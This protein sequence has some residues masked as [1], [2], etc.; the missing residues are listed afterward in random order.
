MRERTKLAGLSGEGRS[1]ATTLLVSTALEWMNSPGSGVSKDKR[2]LLG[3]TD[4]R[5]DAALQAGHFNDFL[6]VSLLRGAILRAV[7]DAGDDGMTEDQFGL[8][9][10]KALGFTVGNKNALVHWMANPEGRTQ[11]RED[12]QRALA[13]VLAHRVWTDLRRGWRYTNPSLSVL[14]LIDVTFS[15]LDDI[16]EDKEGFASILPAL[17]T[18][19][20]PA[21]MALLKT[22]LSAMLEGLAVSAEAL[23]PVEIDVIAQNSRNHL[24]PPW[25]MDAKEKPRSR[26]TL[27]LQ[28]PG[29]DRVGLKE[30]QTIIR[31]GHNSRIGRLINRETMIGTKLGRADYLAML[32]GLMEFLA[33]EGLVSRVDLEADQQGWRLSPSAVRIVPGEALRTVSAQ[34][35]RYFHELYHAIAADLKAGRSHYWGIEGREHTAQVSQRQ[36]EW[37]EWR[38]R[39][40]SEDKENLAKN[41]AELKAAGESEQFLPALFCSPTMELGVDIS[42]LNAVYL[43]NV[44]PT[45]ANYAQR[46]GRAGRSGQAALIMTYCAAQSPHD[47]YFF[48]RRNDM[49]A[50]DVR[51]PALDIS[52]E[53]L[54]RSHL[55]AVWLAETKLALSP[56]IPQI[57]DLT[58]PGYPLKPEISEVIERPKLASVARAPMKRVLDQILDSLHG[59][60]PV[61]MSEPDRFV[62]EV[63]EGAPLEFNRAFKRWRD[64]YASARTQL[65]E[66][67]ERSL[68]TG[69]SASDRRQVK[70]AQMQASDQIALL[71]Q[72]KASNG[73]DFYS[74]RYLATEGFL[75]GYN[76]PRLPLYAF[77]PGEGKTGSFLQR[78][79]FLAISEF[80]PRSLI[81]HEGRAYRVIKAKLPPEVRKGDGAELATK[82]IFICANC[83]ACHDDEVERCHACNSP[84]AGEAQVKGTLRI[85]NVEAALAER[86]TANDEERVRQGFEIQTVFSWP[87]QDGRAD[88]VEAVF[89]CGEKAIL[90]L[91]YAN[92]ADISRINKGLKR[93]AN[94][95][96]FGFYIDPRSGYWAK[97]AD[98]DDADD[99]PPDVVNPVRI[100]PI[101]RDRK[102]ALLSVSEIPRL[103]RLRQSQLSSM[104]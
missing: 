64:L 58:Q 8:R 22:L 19:D 88:I 17:G 2:K 40:E 38:F 76:F 24:R 9:T 77:I 74:Y 70:A 15:G 95:T 28:A 7:L 47:Q 69:L 63:A 44:P 96:E 35:N 31:G 42:A 46:A 29:R 84:I 43:R 67:N 48:E 78:A 18:L 101:V 98:E 66:A 4:N 54:V 57:L 37:R 49:V 89:R 62:S 14:K 83:G 26:T 5:Q 34:G 45:P 25:A 91:Q 87:K 13:K 68:I 41:V 32:T 72:G 61:W 102:N 11:A 20:A 92:S 73:S 86:I 104:P 71:E 79:R 82:D 33:R 6:F 60:N 90:T 56:D 75:P 51:P 23:D 3:F 10:V 65:A 16:A 103:T 36:R 30:E 39:F 80:G 21:R 97:S 27:L 99:E 55:H 94:K 100:V 50:G 81:Y 85:D 1:S 12:A 53:E 93:R 59:R 52:N